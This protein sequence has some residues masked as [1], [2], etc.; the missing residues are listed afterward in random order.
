[1]FTS[2]FSQVGSEYF[3]CN[4]FWATIFLTSVSEI[5]Q[6]VL[7]SEMV[8]TFPNET[9]C[10][11]YGVSVLDVII[12]LEPLLAIESFNGVVEMCLSAP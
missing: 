8:I 10:K 3:R 4:L 12:S 6:N 11:I 7:I 1:M 9:I 5:N 2:H